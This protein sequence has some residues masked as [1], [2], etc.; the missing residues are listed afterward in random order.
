V[1]G[2][3]ETV[4]FAADR[5]LSR[6]KSHK[7][8][9]YQLV[10]GSTITVGMRVKGGSSRLTP[11]PGLISVTYDEPDMISLD[12]SYESRAKMPCGHVIG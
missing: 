4:M 10:H 9:D 3:S 11:I 5:E 6:G 1:S 12:D 2:L 8:S 7:L